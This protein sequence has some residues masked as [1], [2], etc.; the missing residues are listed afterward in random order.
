MALALASHAA[1]IKVPDSIDFAN[2][3]TSFKYSNSSQSSTGK[4][5]GWSGWL[6]PNGTFYVSGIYFGENIDACSF[7]GGKAEVVMDNVRRQELIK[8]ALLS[9]NE[10]HDV[11]SGDVRGSYELGPRLSVQLG[12]TIANTVIAKFGDNT[13]NFR[14]EL[15]LEVQ[16]VFNDSKLRQSA[17]ELN[18]SLD[19]DQAKVIYTLTNIGKQTATLMLPN[20]A[21]TH[22]IF[23]PDN[24]SAIGLSY[25]MRVTNKVINLKSNATFKV[26]LQVPKN[27]DIHKGVFLYDNLSTVYNDDPEIMASPK[28]QICKRVK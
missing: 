22:F 11:P 24:A 7:R 8:L 17:L 20:E 10:N 26:T 18:V 28:V 13:N 19:Q 27:V 1:V 16:K 21:G 5:M 6:M 12:P 25:A 4:K 2:T 3:I 14:R 23:R 15:D 9:Y